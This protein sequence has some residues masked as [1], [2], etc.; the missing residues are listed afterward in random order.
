MCGVWGNQLCARDGAHTFVPVPGPLHEE[1]SRSTRE[2]GVL[3]DALD[4]RKGFVDRGCPQPSF[5][6]I[7][8]ED[9]VVF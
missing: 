9:A 5:L 7:Q 3:E 1:L 8:A 6:E 2:H 4:A